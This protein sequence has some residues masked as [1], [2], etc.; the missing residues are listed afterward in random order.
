MLC[1]AGGALFA[2]LLGA[3]LRR[4]VRGHRRERDGARHY[5][6]YACDDPDRPIAL[7]TIGDDELPAAPPAAPGEEAAIGDLALSARD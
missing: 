6:A 1:L 4:V 3:E 7:I 5:A 2:I